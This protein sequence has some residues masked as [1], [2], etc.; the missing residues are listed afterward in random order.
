MCIFSHEHVTLY[1]GLSVRP[2]IRL[3]VRPSVHPCLSVGRSHVFSCK[4]QLYKRLCPSVRW[5][6]RQS[7]HPTVRGSVCQA[8]LK[9]REFK[10]I[11]DFLQLLAG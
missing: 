5:S 4:K 9:N 8:F 6:V 7:V 10:K 1:E 3:F 11:H 2:S